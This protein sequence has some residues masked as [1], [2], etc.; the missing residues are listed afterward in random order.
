[1]LT[2]SYTFKF[3]V[4]NCLW[5]PLYCLLVGLYI[6]LSTACNKSLV[7]RPPLPDFLACHIDET[8]SQ[9]VCCIDV[10]AIGISVKAQL[11]LNLC[12]NSITT[13]FEETVKTVEEALS[14]YDWGELF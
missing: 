13:G 9:I 10:D 1:M 11:D 4:T 2:C 12:E 5:Q 14:K 3:K 8:C 7:R 6:F